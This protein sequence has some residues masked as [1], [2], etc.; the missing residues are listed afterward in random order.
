MINESHPKSN[1]LPRETHHG[2]GWDP[3]KHNP[4][5]PNW[6]S[7]AT[8]L[9]KVVC[10]LRRNYG[11][12]TGMVAQT[13]GWTCLQ[14]KKP[15]RYLAGCKKA[16][17]KTLWY[18]EVVSYT[19][20]PLTPQHFRDIYNGMEMPLCGLGNLMLQCCGTT[21]ATVNI[22]MLITQGNCCVSIQKQNKEDQATLPCYT[23]DSTV[24][25]AINAMVVVQACLSA[26]C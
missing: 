11:I 4:S 13:Q 10:G 26:R 7:C 6:H 17:A 2:V 22:E 15:D 14:E 16:F 24:Y 1:A 9:A 12:P 25:L 18:D 21:F 23:S 19:C 8:I 5:G 3:T 20:D